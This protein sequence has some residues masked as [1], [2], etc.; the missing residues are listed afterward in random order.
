M[1]SRRNA[2]KGGIV[3]VSTAAAYCV[4]QSSFRMT[5]AAAQQQPQYSL[6]LQGSSEFYGVSVGVYRPDVA[7]QYMDQEIASFGRFGAEGMIGRLLSYSRLR[8]EQFPEQGDR[9]V[10]RELSKSDTILSQP[11]YN[12]QTTRDLLERADELFWVRENPW[13][14]VGIIRGAY[15]LIIAPL[16][17]AFLYEMGRNIGQDVYPEAKAWFLELI[18]GE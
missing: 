11:I 8:G 16:A 14:L 1:I 4:A 9:E 12:G 10:E 18:E 7:V 5:E 3:M 17:G 6:F 15:K 13:I 2:M